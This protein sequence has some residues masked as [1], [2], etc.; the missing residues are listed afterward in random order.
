M[1]RNEVSSW[2][3]VLFVLGTSAAEVAANG[4]VGGIE[5]E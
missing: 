3:R 4:A 5:N 1:G 2:S